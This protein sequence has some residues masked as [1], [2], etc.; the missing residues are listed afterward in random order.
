LDEYT[1]STIGALKRIASRQVI[2]N[3][4]SLG[5]SVVPPTCGGKRVG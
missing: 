4:G 5:I 1:N 2:K 3:G